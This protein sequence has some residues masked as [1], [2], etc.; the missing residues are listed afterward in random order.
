MIIGVCGSSGSGKSTV[1]SILA[2]YKFTW[3]NCDQIY[4]DLTNNYTP[5]L[6][7]IRKEFGEIVIKNDRLNRKVLA[8]IVF[9]DEQALKRLNEISHFYVRGEL[10]RII[11]DSYEKTQGFII[12][13]PMLFEA[14]LEEICNVIIAVVSAQKNKIDRI[15]NRDGITE[16]NA[17]QRLR[18]QT[19]D[20]ELIRRCDYVIDNNFD[21]T[22]LKKRCSDIMNEIINREK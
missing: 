8:D 12:D 17:S 5:C 22:H 14:K 16:Y 13:A 2:E 20:E 15:I 10:D 11:S 9:N 21:L 19:S 4:H 1:C 6:D 3:L 7:H 18:H